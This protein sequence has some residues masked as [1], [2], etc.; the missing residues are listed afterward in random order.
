MTT[1][2][3]PP[4][5]SPP[6]GGSVPAGGATLV[7]PSAEVAALAKG[8]TIEGVVLAV[9][10]KNQIQVQTLLGTLALQTTANVPINSVITLMV[11]QLQPQQVLQITSL[12]GAPL[13]LSNSGQSSATL[14]PLA[15]GA[16][17]Q[18]T[19]LRPATGVTPPISTGATPSS[20]GAAGAVVSAGTQAQT[21]QVRVGGST[22]SGQGATQSPTSQGLAQGTTQGSGQS[23][24][25]GNVQSAQSQSQSSVPATQATQ[26]TRS[27]PAAQATQATQTTQA[28]QAGS[29]GEK[30]SVPATA[31]GPSTSIKAGA[32]NTNQTV[33][34]AGTKFNA[35]V[36]KIN[37]PGNSPVSASGPTASGAAVT[38]A[39]TASG[40]TTGQ[41]LMLA[42][43]TVIVGTI[44]GTTATGQPIVQLPGATIAL[45]V[46]GQVATGSRISLEI[47]GNIQ[48]PKQTGAANAMIK[49]GMGETFAKSSSWSSLTEALRAIEIAD[50]ARFQQLLQNIV[51]Q[52]GTKLSS[53][54]LFFLNALRGGDFRSWIGDTP[55]RLIERERPGLINKL[56]NEFQAMGKL[57]DE[58]S[59][60][61]WRMAMIPLYHNEQVERIRLYQRRARK[62]DDDDEDGKRFI[63]DFSL[64][65]L[66][67]LQI[68]GLV[69]SDSSR[70]D[71]IIRTEKS[72]GH[73]AQVEI[74]QIYNEA[75]E[76]TGLG[77]GIA[78]QSAPGNF[79]DFPS[80]ADE[81]D[82]DGLIV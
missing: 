69:K 72:L 53:Q 9:L 44:T 8:T 82:H 17:A 73:K 57:A 75:A 28:A 29:G 63:L 68:D 3:P 24:A 47:T 22:S 66:G 43:G 58:Q 13:P 16:L 41:T 60:G 62:R 80:M 77:G 45:D 33:L 59:S 39:Q 19:L 25:T 14:P 76:L 46:L 52:T 36:I 34:A 4:P 18:A 64:S 23:T 27:T 5:P 26:S 70:V 20:G 54:M 71:L 6:S 11:S 10:A 65:K 81:T 56:G 49:A 74:A 40:A 50:P 67:H 32:T 42:R 31:G 7:S 38:G 55:A 2:L 1:V 78:F 12:N 48:A 51:P 61:D 35:N 15:P 79:V 21:P 30:P 37:P